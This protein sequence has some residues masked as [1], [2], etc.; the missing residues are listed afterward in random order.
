M[1]D[2]IL[3]ENKNKLAGIFPFQ[4]KSRDIFHLDLSVDNQ[5]LFSV[6]LSSSSKLESYIKNKLKEAN[7]S[8]ALGGYAED[9]LIYRKSSLF[10]NDE[11][12]RTIHLGIDV[13][14]DAN[15]SILSPYDGIIHSFQNNNNFGDY[16]PTIIVQHQIDNYTFYTLYG[17]L[18]EASLEGLKP[19]NKVAKGDKIAELGDNTEN[20]NWPPHLHLQLISDMEDKKGDFPGVCSKK[21]KN[22]YLNIC[23]N[24]ELILNI[25]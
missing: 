10:G 24:P 20:G 14:Y 4:L 19:G 21:D 8:I 5:E 12:A 13:W 22:H 11:N 23:H 15:T 18:S 25:R 2:K 3:L 16:G 9:R 7:K 17:H 1:L 6:D